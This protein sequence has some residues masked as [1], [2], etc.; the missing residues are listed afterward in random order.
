MSKPREPWWG[1]VLNIVRLYP[2]HKQKLDDMHRQ[3]TTASF[4]DVPRVSGDGRSL[5]RIALR[6][7]HPEEQR[8]YEAVTAAILKTQGLAHGSIVLRMI[9]LVHW[10][11]SHTLDGAAMSLGISS[12]TAKRYHAEFIRSVGISYGFVPRS[13]IPQSQENVV[14]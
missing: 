11:R 3:S 13:L 10:K 9:D 2:A 12:A 7:L 1:H 4:S 5:E 6:T 14:N 8:E